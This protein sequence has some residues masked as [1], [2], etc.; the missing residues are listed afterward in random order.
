ML[1]SNSSFH[2]L[3]I[4]S[5]LIP[6]LSL[7]FLPSSSFASPFS[8]FPSLFNHRLHYIA[9]LCSCAFFLCLLIIFQS[10][11]LALLLFLSLYFLLHQIFPFFIFF[12]FLLTQIRLR[13]IVVFIKSFSFSSLSVFFYV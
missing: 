13:I 10:V 11:F 3:L 6:S 7:T 1:S 5:F 2:L 9:A 12:L 8:F 4:L